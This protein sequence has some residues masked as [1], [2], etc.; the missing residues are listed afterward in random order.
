[1]IACMMRSEGLADLEACARLGRVR[2]AAVMGVIVTTLFLGGIA[3]A[4]CI[5]RLH[6]SAQRGDRVLSDLRTVLREHPKLTVAMAYGGEGGEYELTF[7][8]PHLLFAGQPL[9]VDVIAC[10][11]SQR[12]RRPLPPETYE[13]LQSGAVQ[14]WLVPKGGRPFQKK[15]WYPP[16]QNVFPADFVDI[17]LE[18]YRQ[19]ESS[20]YFDLW[21][22]EEP[23]RAEPAAASAAPA[24]S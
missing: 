1:M 6:W 9:L 23:V 13:A 2:Q 7:Y 21:F 12:S 18:R 24:R 17:L 11:E 22:Y 15:N 16:H 4:K 20:E 3:E 10:M 14:L 8:R 5:Q 19:R